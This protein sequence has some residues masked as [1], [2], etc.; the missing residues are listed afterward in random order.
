VV[1]ARG[2]RESGA[3]IIVYRDGPY[4]GQD[5]YLL[6]PP[7][8]L[9]ACG[10]QG[11]YQRTGQRDGMGRIVYRWVTAGASVARQPLVASSR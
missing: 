2:V 6:P 1:V 3:M 9:A 7:K 8:R 10:G 4:A 11:H 5:D